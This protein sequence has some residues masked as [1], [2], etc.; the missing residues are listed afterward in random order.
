MSETWGMLD[1]TGRCLI[2]TV[3]LATIGCADDSG[4]RDSTGSISSQPAAAQQVQDDARFVATEEQGSKIWKASGA[5]TSASNGNA[6]SLNIRNRGSKPLALKAINMLSAE[7]GFAIDTM[8]VKE[9]LK[10]GEERTISVPLENIDPSVTEHRVYCQLH[11]KHVAAI[12]IVMKDQNA[13]TAPKPTP[14]TQ[15]T[16]QAAGAVAPSLQAGEVSSRVTESEGQRLL[17]EQSRKQGEIL[18]TS[19]E[20]QAPNSIEPKACEG[21]PGFDRGCPGASK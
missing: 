20:E 10:P 17:R 2:V 12:L 1:W 18:S 7:H 15:G 5:A 6:V 11:P 4:R 13:A 9:V 21:F 16:G 19:R 8:K 14:A 3:F